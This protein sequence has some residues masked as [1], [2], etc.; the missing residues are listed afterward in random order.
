MPPQKFYL[1]KTNFANYHARIDNMGDYKR[2]HIGSKKKCVIIDVYDEDNVP[3]IEGISY[4]THCTTS[5]DMIRGAGT[6]HMMRASLKFICNMFPK[7]RIEI[8]R[9]KDTSFIE[10]KRNTRISLA[11][12]H[13]FHHNCTW[14][15][16]KF[17]AS[18]IYVSQGV[19]KQQ[20]RSLKQAMH[21]DP[22]PDYDKLME[23]A[24]EK[25]RKY[26]KTAYATCA[27]M[28]EFA[29]LL[30]RNQVDCFFYQTW[31]AKYIGEYVPNVSDSDWSISIHSSGCQDIQVHIE[32]L[33]DA[34]QDI[35]TMRGGE[36][37]GSFGSIGDDL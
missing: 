13:M 10:G 2:V 15:E 8:F 34:P 11:Q 5:A 9:L 37:I 33:T 3:Q 36:N 29:D 30:K 32:T 16:S 20:K 18:P 14:Y 28:Q 25:V 35:F 4:H 23:H 19:Y 27:T 21:H 26:F 22:K 12:H 17:N 7:K 24:P 1:I 6:I 31:L